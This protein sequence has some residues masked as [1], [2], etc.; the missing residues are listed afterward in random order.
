MN[1]FW[2]FRAIQGHSG[3]AFVDLAMQ[4]NV[5]LPDNFFEHIFHVGNSHDVHSI[6]QSG[7]V[8][9]TVVSPMRVDQHK[10]VEYD[11]TKP[12]V[13]VFKNNWKVHQNTVYWCN[14]KVAQKKGLQFYQTRSNAI[15][16]YNTLFAI[17]IEKV[18]FMKSQK[19]NCTI[20]CFNLQRL[21]RKPV[22]TPNLHHGRQDFS[23]PEARTSAA[24]QSKESEEYGETRSEEFEETRSGNFDFRIQ[25]LPHS[26]VQKEDD[27]S[28][29]SVKK[30][31]HYFETDPS[32]WWQTWTRTKI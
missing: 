32:R 16:F 15:V 18:V 4:D 31:V 12:R 26:T 28:R 30:F 10:E 22:P 21:P 11:L 29:E 19:K 3:G 14:L 5:V 2:Y 20:K 24:H 9:F 17:C 25:G 23:N 13:A 1:I 7:A 8:F 27:V 6:I